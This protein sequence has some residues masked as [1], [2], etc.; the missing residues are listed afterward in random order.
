MSAKYAN[1]I[2]QLSQETHVSKIILYFNQ[3]NTNLIYGFAQCGRWTYIRMFPRDK[4]KV[5]CVIK[6]KIENFTASFNNSV[7]F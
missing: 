1:F 6:L 5:S 7:T 4:K 2:T 3:R